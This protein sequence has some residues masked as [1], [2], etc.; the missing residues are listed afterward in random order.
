MHGS[1][2]N[3]LQSDDTI[4]P[5]EDV[6]F[7]TKSERDE[8]F[9]FSL[10]INKRLRDTKLI[11]LLCAIC[12]AIFIAALYA[13]RHPVA[14]RYDLF[15]ESSVQTP[16]KA[17]K[18]PAFRQEWRTLTASQRRD[19]IS[20]VQCLQS[21]LSRI[22]L[23]HSLHDEFTWIHSRLGNFSTYLFSIKPSHLIQEASLLTPGVQPT[24]LP[25]L[26][27]GIDISGYI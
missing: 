18:E 7:I 26:L 4:K 11:F 3:V 6:L 25:H 16:W 22:G 27:P 20:A 15:P 12:T 24:L 19:Y 2:P 1:I 10:A 14:K 13:L 5:H 17:C 23:P 8:F 21:Q 9:P